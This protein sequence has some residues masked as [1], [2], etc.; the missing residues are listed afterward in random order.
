[1]A[2]IDRPAGRRVAGRRG[3]PTVGVAALRRARHYHQRR[4][5]VRRRPDRRQRVEDQTMTYSYIEYE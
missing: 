2:R 3:R 1:M 5:R 4:R